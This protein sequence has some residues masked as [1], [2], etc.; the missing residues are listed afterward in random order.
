MNLNLV[1]FSYY[2]TYFLLPGNTGGGS[3]KKKLK[4]KKRL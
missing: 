1:I 2:G 3:L 4:Q